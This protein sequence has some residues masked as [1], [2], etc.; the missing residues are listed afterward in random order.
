MQT[1]RPLLLVEDDQIDARTVKRALQDVGVIDSIVHLKDGEEALAYLQS[2]VND[3]PCLILLDINMP[4]MNGSEFLRE[5]K[6]DPALRRI[7]VVI[8]T[9]S[10]DQEDVQGTFQDGA[11]GYMVKPLDY[12]QFVDTIKTIGEYWAL[13]VK[14]AHV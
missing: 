1:S 14:P 3:T 2:S 10:M 11:A 4:R 5:V 13:S 7:P 9:T 6:Q 12:P 8:L